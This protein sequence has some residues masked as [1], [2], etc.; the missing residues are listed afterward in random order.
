MRTHTIVDSPIGPLTLVATDGVLS[1]LHMSM[2]GDSERTSNFGTRS[3]IGF[4]AAVSQLDEY[5]AGQRAEFDLPLQMDGN[6]FQRDVWHQLTLIPFGQTRSYGEIATAVGDRTLARAVGTACGQN[7]I[8]VIVPCHRVIGA[9][10]KLVGF[11]GGL[12]RKEFLL[13]HENPGRHPIA[14]R[15]F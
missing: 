11:G 7:P 15:L 8:A 10:G 5:F 3:S 4:E 14:L 1:G 9:D 12:D 6:R 2:P 13:H